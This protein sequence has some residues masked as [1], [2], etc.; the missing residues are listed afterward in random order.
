MRFAGAE[1]VCAGSIWI[2]SNWQ[3][4]FRPGGELRFRYDR[5]GGTGR[6]AVTGEE[7]CI[8]TGLGR[9]CY[10]LY[11]D[12]SGRFYLAGATGPVPAMVTIVR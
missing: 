12:P 11:R 10:R 3:L 2:T 8:A 5:A 6:Y 1:G 9:D 7:L 4:E